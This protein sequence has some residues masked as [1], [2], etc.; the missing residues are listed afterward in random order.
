MAS[1]RQCVWNGAHVL[2]F[3]I[4][5]VSDRTVH[6]FRDFIKTNAVECSLE[7]RSAFL[8]CA[9]QIPFWFA[10]C[11][12]ACCSSNAITETVKRFHTAVSAVSPYKDKL[13]FNDMSV[14]QLHLTF[15]DLWYKNPPVSS[16]LVHLPS[17]QPISLKCILILSS[18]FSIIH[19]SPFTKVFLAI[20]LFPSHATCTSHLILRDLTV[21]A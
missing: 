6:G 17:S 8:L 21:L 12:L 15:Q 19:V 3:F 10:A 13:V 14:W 2:E 1:C 16:R 4:V 20:I 9:L 11:A 5:S 18:C 7:C